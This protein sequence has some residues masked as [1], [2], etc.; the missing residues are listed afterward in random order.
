M[1][2][3]INT[4]QTICKHGYI[5]K[6]IMIIWVI[7]GEM[8]KTF[9]FKS[10]TE[11]SLGYNSATCSLYFIMLKWRVIGLQMNNTNWNEHM[12]IKVGSIF[13]ELPMGI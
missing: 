13:A 6:Y 8:A 2:L 12:E 10:A 3:L 1:S 7:I 11:I 5:L 9:H 4:S